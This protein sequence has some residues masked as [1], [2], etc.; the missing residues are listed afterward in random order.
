[1]W[2]SC[3]AGKRGRG[4]GVESLG[5]FEVSTD[6]LQCRC[7]SPAERESQRNQPLEKWMADGE[8]WLVIRQVLVD[9]T[10][11]SSVLQ[12]SRGNSCV[13]YVEHS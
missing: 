4:R 7:V 12:H 3:R 5:G 2:L 9:T 8:K 11:R 6:V 10:R 13:S 1:M